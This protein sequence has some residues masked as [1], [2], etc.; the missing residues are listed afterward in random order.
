[1]IRNISII[2]ILIISICLSQENRLFYD[3]RDWNDIRKKSNFI[4]EEVEY[5]IKS[6]YING[7][8]DG[9]LYGY[10]K[11]WSENPTLANEVFGEQVDYLTVRENYQKFKLF[12]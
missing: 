4:D 2:S 11:T 12:L 10:L 3:G 7:V 1:M 5:K 8:L 9:R 6:S